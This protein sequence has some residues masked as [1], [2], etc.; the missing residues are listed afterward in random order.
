MKTMSV[1]KFNITFNGRASFSLLSISK[2]IDNTYNSKNRRGMHDILIF[3]A[4]SPQGTTMANTNPP[5]DKK[6]SLKPPT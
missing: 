1:N 2:S 4:S 3:L 6:G 5:T